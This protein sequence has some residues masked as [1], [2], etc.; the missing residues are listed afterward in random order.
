[1]GRVYLSRVPVNHLLL[2]R[3]CAIN[4]TSQPLSLVEASPLVY[5]L[6]VLTVTLPVS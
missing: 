2:S 4:S 5:P 3:G 6:A 1:M